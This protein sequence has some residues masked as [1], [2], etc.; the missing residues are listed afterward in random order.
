MVY[1]TQ[2]HSILRLLLNKTWSKK[3]GFI[4][5]YVKKCKKKIG[6]LK[7]CSD[8]ETNGLCRKKS[9]KKKQ[10]Q[11]KIRNLLLPNIENEMKR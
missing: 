2:M 4:Q 10:K 11:R 8:L 1:S 3:H 5:T 6:L 7:K 9:H